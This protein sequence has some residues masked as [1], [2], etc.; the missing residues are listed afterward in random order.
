MIKLNNRDY[1]WV[2][3][4]TVKAIMEQNNFVYSRIIVSVNSKFIP[5][6][7]YAITIVQDG[8]NVKAMHLLAGG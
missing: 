4:L 3:G 6:E 7:D 2:E 8:D 1:E 5:P